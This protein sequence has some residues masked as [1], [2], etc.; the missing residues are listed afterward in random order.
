VKDLELNPA[1][2]LSI[3]RH[4]GG[5]DPSILRDAADNGKKQ[6]RG[7]GSPHLKKVIWF[8]RTQLKGRL[9]GKELDHDRRGRKE[10]R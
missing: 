4:K 3:G 5:S 9:A 8:F 10:E 1:I 6:K 7:K 2:S